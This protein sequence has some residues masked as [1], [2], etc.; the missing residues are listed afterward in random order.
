M[1][2]HIPAPPGTPGTPRTP[3]TPTSATA[4]SVN[5]DQ[6]PPPKKSGAEAKERKRENRAEAVTVM[7]TLYGVSPGDREPEQSPP[8]WQ[9]LD[10]TRH[11]SRVD[12]L[13][14]GRL[15][16]NPDNGFLKFWEEFRRANFGDDEEGRMDKEDAIRRLRALANHWLLSG[17]EKLRRGLVG[18]NG[19]RNSRGKH[20][21]GALRQGRILTA[22]ELDGIIAQGHKDSQRGVR[23]N[24]HQPPPPPRPTT[25]VAPTPR[26]P[27]SAEGRESQTPTTATGAGAGAQPNPP[28]TNRGDLRERLSARNAPLQL[29]RDRSR[30]HE[31]RT[32]S[33]GPPSNRQ[34]SAA[35]SGTQFINRISNE[36]N[37]INRTN[38]PRRSIIEW[39]TQSG[40]ETQGGRGHQGERG[41]GNG[42]TSQP[43]GGGDPSRGN[44]A[45]GEATT[46]AQ[47]EDLEEGEIMETETSNN[48]NQGQGSGQNSNPNQ[49]NQLN[50]NQSNN[51]TQLN[52]SNPNLTQNTR[53]NN[54][55]NSFSGARGQ[56]GAQPRPSTSNPRPGPSNQTAVEDIPL[57]P[58]PP[59][60]ASTQVAAAAAGGENPDEPLEGE[61]GPDRVIITREDG[62]KLEGTNQSE[63]RDGLQK[64]VMEDQEKG[65]R[66]LAFKEWK[67]T[68][69]R[70]EVTPEDGPDQSDG[71]PLTAKMCG[72]ALIRIA[73]SYRPRLYDP[74]QGWQSIQLRAA[75]SSDLPRVALLSIRYPG[76]VGD[77]RAIIEGVRGIGAANSLTLAAR[78][79]F[80]YVQSHET[81][82]E[83]RGAT[84]T[85]TIIRFEVS[86]RVA[87][88]LQQVV[89]RRGGTVR[90]GATHVILQHNRRDVT[91]ESEFNFTS[92]G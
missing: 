83:T 47:F 31:G 79:E 6:Q 44:S 11:S 42:S 77:P 66:Y 81:T 78:E 29:P 70:L 59:P 23:V 50:P 80:R 35:E 67:R 30:S 90:A 3:S 52:Q 63:V 21:Y 7:S 56:R 69:G 40:R 27:G 92:Q 19:D 86:E 43:N 16:L 74:E 62:I 28:S 8:F 38:L 45:S 60:P 75:W 20:F 87:L 4:P 41:R 57:P 25:A 37:Q 72:D 76:S 89:R 85:D 24:H 22:A 33:R 82:S 71:T 64:K 54:Q 32:S 15:L 84:N 9:M 61:D 13:V 49:L 26:G 91:A 53:R 34:Q 18:G 46:P 5:N 10:V 12:I 73:R 36:H 88:E 68:K 65:R 51:P 39:S 1:S 58:P 55:T 14:L 2:L 17:K 48:Q